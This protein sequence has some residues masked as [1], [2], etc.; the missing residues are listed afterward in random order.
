MPPL[1][2]APES[3]TRSA[4]NARSMVASTVALVEATKTL[5]ITTMPTPS[6]SAVPAAAVRLG[7]RM[8]FSRASSPREA[9]QPRQR[10]ADDPAE[11]Q[12]D[13]AAEDVDA[14]EDRE[15]AE[16]EDEPVVGQVAEQAGERRGQPDGQRGAAD[17]HARRRAVAGAADDLG[18]HR[19][20]RRHLAG[21]AGR[22]DR[23]DQRHQD[24]GRQ[25]DDDGP[26]R[27]HQPAGRDAEAERVE[28]RLEPGGDADARRA[29]PCTEARTPTTSAS[30]ST[31]ASTCR[32]VAP[33]A[34][35]SPFCRVRWATVIEKVLKIMNAPTS[36]ATIAK[37]FMK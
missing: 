2:L 31:A 36:S 8:A 30:I 13:R 16:P 24:A 12:R 14:E 29:G 26:G 33:S 20:D 11:R 1:K 3:T 27:Q 23:R 17:D 35:S 34:R 5:M 7:L 6:I 22:R 28:Q 19:G 32:R 21:L 37:K 15:A 10:R 4:V 18:R 25:G 9:A